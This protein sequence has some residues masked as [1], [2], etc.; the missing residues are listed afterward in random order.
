M[1]LI[2]ITV[3]NPSLINTGE[4]P[5]ERT[6]EGIFS[7]ETD[8]DGETGDTG[9]SG[10]GELDD[11]MKAISTLV[12]AA[13]TVAGV[14]KQLRDE[15]KSDVEEESG[16]F[17]GEADEPD[18]GDEEAESFVESVVGENEEAEIEEAEPEE[19]E[20]AEADAE[21][22]AD[23][24]SVGLKVAFVLVVVLVALALWSREGDEENVDE[25]WD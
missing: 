1:A 5:S 8:S 23:S 22:E 6:D 11:K 24:G 17:G 14:I 25:D 20:D 2:E 15:E 7:R 3:D 18:T 4:E 19:A 16:L 9:E 21:T 12:T 13:T 10:D